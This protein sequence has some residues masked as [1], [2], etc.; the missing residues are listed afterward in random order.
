M[1]HLG[2][3]RLA[4]KP[5][6]IGFTARSALE[7]GSEGRDHLVARAMNWR[8]ELKGPVVPAHDRRKNSLTG[9]HR[10]EFTGH[11]ST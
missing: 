5:I 9:W 10:Q 6:R 3:H 11:S 2:S 1:Q 7:P 8:A 4:G